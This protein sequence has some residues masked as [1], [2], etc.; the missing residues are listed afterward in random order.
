MGL[1]G[2]RGGGGGEHKISY[3]LFTFLFFY[4]GCTGRCARSAN[5]RCARSAGLNI[6]SLTKWGIFEVFSDHV[7][8]ESNGT[9]TFKFDFAYADTCSPGSAPLPLYVSFDAFL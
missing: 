4:R 9:M 3:G 6:K 8:R 2:R 1:W 7:K 5:T